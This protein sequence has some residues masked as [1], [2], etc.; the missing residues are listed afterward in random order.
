MALEH[1]EFTKNWEN[2]LDF[3]TYEAEEY[4]I[5]AD[6][7]LLH[8]EAKAALNRLVDQLSAS[9]GGAQVGFRAKDLHAASVQEAIEEVFAALQ[10]ASMGVV[11]NGSV[12]ME[13]MAGDVLQRMDSHMETAGG[14]F[15]GPVYA[16]SGVDSAAQLRNTGIV[17]VDTDPACNGQIN[18][19]YG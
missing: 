2:P 3:P 18:W 9:D 6:M 19:T 14:A 5:R 4:K 8:D 1:L 17:E 12:T 7:Q 15:T 13:K 16:Q 10:E 11:P